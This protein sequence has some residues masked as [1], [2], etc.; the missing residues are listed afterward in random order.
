MFCFADEGADG[1]GG[2]VGAVAE[3]QQLFCLCY[4]ITVSDIAIPFCVSRL[5]FRYH[6]SFVPIAINRDSAFA[7][8]INRDSSWYSD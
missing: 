8:A 6:D 4:R 7:Y 2:G 3:K 5:N 1:L